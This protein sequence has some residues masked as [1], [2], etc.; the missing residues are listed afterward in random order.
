ME[1]MKIEI[2]KDQ[3]IYWPEI[4]DFNYRWGFEVFYEVEF[5]DKEIYEFKSQFIFHAKER[6]IY[7][8]NMNVY[9][10]FENINWEYNNHTD[11]EGNLQLGSTDSFIFYN[12]YYVGEKKIEDKHRKS[13]LSAFPNPFQFSED[14]ENNELYY[15]RNMIRN[16][17]KDNHTKI[18]D[19][20]LENKESYNSE[21]ENCLNDIKII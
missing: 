10:P 19:T 15:N 12:T 8:S 7:Y 3:I 21:I 16:W 14:S 9:I 17:W 1:K 13:T 20:I 11:E 2:K 18:I 6:K 4:T 5:F